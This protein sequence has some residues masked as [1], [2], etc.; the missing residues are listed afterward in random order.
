[1]NTFQLQIRALRELRGI[2]TREVSNQS[3]LAVPQIYTLETG[4]KFNPTLG[5]LNK[6]L[7]PLGAR[8]T[9]SLSKPLPALDSKDIDR[10]AHK[11]SLDDDLRQNTIEHDG[12]VSE[13]AKHVE[14]MRT[15]H[16]QSVYLAVLEGRFT[17]I[18]SV[19][20]NLYLL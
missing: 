17:E 19:N 7:T 12:E 6:L 13:I 15:R 14:R 18:P 4:K 16:A 10:E 3:G 8:I 20:Y 9:I 2:P 5:T 1:M 11:V